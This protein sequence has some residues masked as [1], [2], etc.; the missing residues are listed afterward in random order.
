[1]ESAN[2][3]EARAIDGEVTMPPDSPKL[4]QIRIEPVRVADVPTDEVIAP[5]KIELNPNMQAHVSLP[6]AGRVIGVQAKI[7]DFVAKGAPVLTLESPDLDQAQSAN[8]QAEAGVNQAKANLL[9]A[10]A[11]IDRVKDLAEHKAIAQK[12]V[13]NAENALAQAR[14]ALEQAQAAHTQSLRRLELFGLKPGDFSQKLIITAPISGKVMD[15]NVVPGEYRNDTTGPVMTIADLST[16]WVSSDVPES[17]IRFIQTGE[18]LEIEL[19]AYPGETFTGKVKRI[20]DTVDPQTRTV[21]VRAEMENRG[22][23]LRPEMFGKIRHVEG[24][25]K[26]IVVPS[27]AILQGEAENL[28]WVERAPG[29][30]APVP[31]KLG[32]KVRDGFAIVKGLREGDRVVVDGAM[33]LK[34]A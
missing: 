10:Q 26:G 9:K 27:G 5:G 14:S 8:L 7:G 23:R 33:L 16:V 34:G 28:V 13:L 25:S 15:M 22:G 24:I 29:R 18:R 19:A 2:P 17:E 31:V 1:V 30:F 20:A 11:D 4:R 21:K 32:A 6:F 12:E 3:K